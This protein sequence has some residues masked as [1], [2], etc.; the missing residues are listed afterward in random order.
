M[1]VKIRVP[2][3]L[4]N[5]CRII[6]GTPKGTIILTTTHVLFPW[7]FL[8]GPMNMKNKLLRLTVQDLGIPTERGLSSKHM[9]GESAT[10]RTS[11]LS[12]SSEGRFAYSAEWSLNDTIK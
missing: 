6:I 1:V 11:A 5:R 9:F 3:T 7:L 4:N 8:A 2:F 10:I 12:S